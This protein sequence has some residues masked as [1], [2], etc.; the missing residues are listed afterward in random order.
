MLSIQIYSRRGCHLCEQLIEEIMPLVRGRAKLEVL[1]IDNSS[2]WQE[3]YGMRV[4]VVE[5]G[6]RF[7]CQYKL[8]RD[9][10]Q[11]VLN[12]LEA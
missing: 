3:E 10:L 11:E 9:V 12:G 7:I 8:D 4:P 5:I 2:E 6:G 1:N